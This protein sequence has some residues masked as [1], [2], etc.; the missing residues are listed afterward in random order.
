MYNEQIEDL[1]DSVNEFE[2]PG[3]ETR[4]EIVYESNQGRMHHDDVVSEKL[5]QWCS[6]AIVVMIVGLACVACIR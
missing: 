6:W 1:L 3:E 4:P 5:V 2:H